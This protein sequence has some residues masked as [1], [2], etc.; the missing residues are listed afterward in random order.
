MAFIVA[1]CNWCSWIYKITGFG[2]WVMV[3]LEGGGWGVG[4]VSDVKF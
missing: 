2:Y 3:V 4:V 1:D